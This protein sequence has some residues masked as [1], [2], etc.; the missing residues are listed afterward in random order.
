MFWRQIIDVIYFCTKVVAAMLSAAKDLINFSALVYQMIEVFL[1]FDGKIW[2]YGVNF[3]EFIENWL[4]CYYN[5]IDFM[6]YSLCCIKFKSVILITLHRDNPIN[7]A[8]VIACICNLRW[9][10]MVS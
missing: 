7:G 4:V 9:M 10:L 3:V 2:F 1:K 8:V 6:L 5:T